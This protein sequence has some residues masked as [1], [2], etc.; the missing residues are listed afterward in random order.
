MVLHGDNYLEQEIIQQGS[1]ERSTTEFFQNTL[2]PGMTVIDIGANI[3]YFSLLSANL[4]GPGGQVHSFEPYPGYVERFKLSL[5]QNNFSNIRLNEFALSNRKETHKL[6]KGLSSARMHK[7]SHE[8]PVYNQ[9]HD[10]IEV[11]CVSLDEYA[12]KFLERVDFIKIDVDGYEARI[13]KGAHETIQKYKPIVLI[14][15]FESAL[16][17]A[18]ASVFELLQMFSAWGYE[19]Y[20]EQDELLD[21]EHLMATSTANS[22]QSVNVAFKPKVQE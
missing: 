22:M 4:V 15:L 3:G 7:W 5:A 13:L 20:S 10:E 6:Y 17:D 11:N 1:W 8:D 2:K 19:P 14:E 12:Q 9:V 21:Y 16:R 18:G